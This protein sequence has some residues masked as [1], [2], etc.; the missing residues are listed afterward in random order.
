M[1]H[2]NSPRALQALVR[3][4]RLF[5]ATTLLCGAAAI[6]AVQWPPQATIP[7][8]L[9]VQLKANTDSSATLDQ[10]KGLGLQW[11]RR[12]FIWE[13]V[14]KEKGVYDFSKYD[15]IM[16]DCKARGLK[17]VGCLA[18]SNKLYG[19]AKDEPGRTAYAKFAAAMVERYKGQDIVWEIWNEPNTM[20]FWGK[21]GKKGNSKDYAD[22][23]LGLV[24]AA[25]PA[26]KKADPKCIIL[27]GSVS[28]MWTE[29]YKWMDF[30]FEAGVLKTGIDGWSVHPYGLKS[31]EDY[32]EAY[33]IMRKSMAKHGG[34]ATI[35]VLN[36]ERG[37]PLG[38]QAEGHAGG[39]DTLAKEYQA[40]HVVRQFLVD[41][42]CD[43][44]VTIWYEWIGSPKEG[45]SLYSPTEV[46]PAYT[47]AE[48]LIQQLRGYR[49]NKRIE[50]GDPRDF[51]LSFVT[52]TGAE[53]IVV[54]TSPPPHQ[55]VDQTKPH[56]VKV[57]VATNG[58][59][60]VV[61]IYGKTGRLTA[62][63]GFVELTASGAPQYLVVK[64]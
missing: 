45:F 46:L 10:V 23:Y 43:V 22:E 2:P 24:K 34:P 9:G 42:L 19:H 16:A 35:P 32:I 64:K 61:D 62:K 59:I 5:A 8:G 54:W 25:V 17:V 40:W 30:I 3:S 41:I 26:M 15:R 7:E 60:D 4:S 29:S 6:A 11:V 36:T 14:E 63:G 37:F 53:K 48:V 39:G 20:T 55:K 58:Q 38:K 27:G 1:I 21:H 50:I 33:D 52:K 18:F 13:A 57:P 51:A 47:A 49:L 44:N 31:P 28:N 56:A 12:G